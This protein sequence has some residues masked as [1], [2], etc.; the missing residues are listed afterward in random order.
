MAVTEESNRLLLAL[1]RVVR[2]ALVEDVGAGDLTTEAVVGTDEK[3]AAEIVL[4]QRG[5][6]CGLDAAA[7]VFTALDADVRFEPLAADGDRIDDVP[8]AV[9]RVEGPARAVLTGERTALNLLARLSGIATAT[10]GFADAVAGTGAVVLDTRKTTPGLRALEK[11]AVACGG[12]RNHRFG[13]DDGILV[14]DNHLALA[15]GIRPAVERL[16]SA[17]TE[18]PI[19]VEAETIG[20]VRDAVDAGADIVLL[21]NMTPAELREA[22]ALARGRVELEASGGVSLETVRAIAETGVDYVSV[23]ALTH[24]ARSLDVSM[25]VL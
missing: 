5:T 25:E 4:K 20:D 13:L 21:D 18:L 10:R 16:R 3:C 9:V 14:K 7:A 15:G 17:G 24:S 6:V 2:E 1:D 8:R 23:G 22:V 19:E 12:G 11:Y